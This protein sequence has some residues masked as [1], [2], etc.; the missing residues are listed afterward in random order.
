MEIRHGVW[1]AY[2]ISTLQTNNILKQ[3][4]AAPNLHN[5][6]NTATASEIVRICRN[7]YGR[8]SGILVT[9]LTEFHS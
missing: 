5:C 2:F 1:P 9:F 6:V 4:I 3:T 7:C 8:Q